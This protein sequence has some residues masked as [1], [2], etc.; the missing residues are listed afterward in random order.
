MS[1][2]ESIKSSNRRAGRGRKQFRVNYKVSA[3]ILALFFVMLSTPIEAQTP[4]SQDA[5]TTNIKLSMESATL[6][7]RNHGSIQIIPGDSQVQKEEKV[8]AETEKK[9]A[10]AKKRQTIAREYRV[11]ADPTSF[12]DIYAAAGNKFG[13]DP[14]ILKAIH[15][16]ETG[17]SGSTIRSNP[18]GATGP[19]Q[20]LPSTFRRHAVDGNGDGIKDIANVQDAIY[21]AAEYLVACGYPNVKQALWGYNPSSSYYSRVLNIAKNF[22]YGQ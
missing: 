12:N 9:A 7:A 6:F 10:E 3:V 5:Q 20:F 8:K 2:F 11:Y 17:A 14:T 19:M 16:V 13:V 1:L 18:S 21:T 22:G 15:V 4:D